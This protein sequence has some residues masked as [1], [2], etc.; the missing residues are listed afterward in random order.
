MREDGEGEGERGKGVRSGKGWGRRAV[1][2]I[3][4]TGA[5]SASYN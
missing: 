3:Q 4:G 1:A 2:A 5:A